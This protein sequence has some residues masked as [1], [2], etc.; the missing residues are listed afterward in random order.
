MGGRFDCDV[1]DG[2]QNILYRASLMEFLSSSYNLHMNVSIDSLIAPSTSKSVPND[3]SVLQNSG[4]FFSS[5][6]KVIFHLE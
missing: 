5:L 1:R 3:F 2:E 6:K 4:L